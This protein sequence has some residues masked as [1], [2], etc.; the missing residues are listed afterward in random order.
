MGI[1]A[2]VHATE[3]KNAG[4]KQSRSVLTSDSL[5]VDPGS[6]IWHFFC[7][8]KINIAKARQRGPDS[9]ERE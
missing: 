2:W 7:G 5:Y 3:V 1:G 4:N 9:F 8:H 6:L